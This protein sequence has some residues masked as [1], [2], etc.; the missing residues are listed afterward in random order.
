MKDIKKPYRKKRKGL[1]AK[2]LF[3]LS[4]ALGIIAGV[5]FWIFISRCGNEECFFNYDPLPEMFIGGIIGAFLYFVIWGMT[6][7]T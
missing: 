6:A 2:W 4:T 3:I 1:S 7:E 5:C